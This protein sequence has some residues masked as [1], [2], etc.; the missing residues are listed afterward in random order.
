MKKLI[1]IYLLFTVS[2]V[3]QEK[4]HLEYE[5]WDLKSFKENCSKKST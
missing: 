2:I 5:E 3:S 4:I 1:L